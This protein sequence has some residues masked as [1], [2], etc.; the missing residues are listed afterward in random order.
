MSAHQWDAR[1][2][3]NL[4]DLAEE[5]AAAI[6][7]EAELHRHISQALDLVKDEPPYVP[8][9]GPTA[10]PTWALSRHVHEE[11]VKRVLDDVEPADEWEE[12]RVPGRFGWRG[13]L[14]FGA[15]WLVGAAIVVSVV[16]AVVNVAQW[17]WGLL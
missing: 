9:Y 13:V 10:L 2:Y 16:S 14:F 17:A 15:L 8:P 6:V 12:P 11:A 4:W 5:Q 1:D 7:A 3:A